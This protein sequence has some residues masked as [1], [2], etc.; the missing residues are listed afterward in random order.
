[1]R[2][3]VNCSRLNVPTFT[4]KLSPS[5]DLSTTKKNSK[6][7]TTNHDTLCTHNCNIT[8]FDLLVFCD[9]KEQCSPRQQKTGKSQTKL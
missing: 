8:S 5:A 2:M 3:L 6:C 4:V 9:Y 1:M 7:I